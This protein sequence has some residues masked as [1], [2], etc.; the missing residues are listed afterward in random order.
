MWDTALHLARM[1]AQRSAR[2]SADAG[3]AG[4]GWSGGSNPSSGRNSFARAVSFSEEERGGPP[5]EEDRAAERQEQ[6]ERLRKTEA[7]LDTVKKVGAPHTKWNRTEPPYFVD[8]P[9]FSLR[10]ARRNGWR[11]AARA[12]AR[13]AFGCSFEEKGG[14]VHPMTAFMFCWDVVVALAVLLVMVQVPVM[15]AFTPNAQRATAYAGGSAAAFLLLFLDLLLCLLFAADLF[16]GLRMGY[17]EAGAVVLDPVAIRRRYVRTR[18]AWD[19]VAVLPLLLWPVELAVAVHC[20][21]AGASSCSGGWLLVWL[22]YARVLL[23]AKVFTGLAKMARFYDGLAN[24]FGTLATDM[25]TLMGALIILT[26]WYT[27]LWFSVQAYDPQGDPGDDFARSSAWFNGLRHSW[28]HSLAC[29]NDDY[30]VSPDG[31]PPDNVIDPLLNRAL[32]R[33]LDADAGG[34]GPLTFTDKTVLFIN[35]FYWASNAGDGYETVQTQERVVAIAGQI[36]INNL[37]YAFILGSIISALQDFHRGWKKKTTYRSKIDSVNEFLDKHQLQENLKTAARNHYSSVWLPE[38][39][40]FTED[41]LKKDLPP[42]LQHKMM[43][44]VTTD[45]IKSSQFYEK[46]FK[47]AIAKDERRGHPN[48]LV[49]Y[50]ENWIQDMSPKFRPMFKQ[51][52]QFIIQEGTRGTDMYILKEGTAAIHLQNE[53]KVVALAGPGDIFG[54]LGMLEIQPRRTASVVTLS[55]ATVYALSR[56]DFCEILEGMPDEGA[57]ILEIMLTVARKRTTSNLSTPRGRNSSTAQAAAAAVAENPET[58]TE[59]AAAAE[60]EGADRR[61]N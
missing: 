49:R 35:C 21:F 23:F 2:R 5:G 56:D 8:D 15:I 9:P 42:H 26:T 12:L 55:N 47:E 4:D 45:V 3:G 20:R 18:L 16:L 50:V 24:S 57:A 33:W 13:R 38:Q 32:G 11:W 40:D 1:R 59:E 31:C 22:S 58:D 37:F 34:G 48:N 41:N 43:S 53:N 51:P 17:L 28:L 30:S 60:A 36:M 39:M 7:V 61:E 54:E 46:Y 19:A 27:C 14:V 44:T 52:C 6:R 25:G 10:V 29:E